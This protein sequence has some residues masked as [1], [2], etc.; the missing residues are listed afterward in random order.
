MSLTRPSTPA[1]APPAWRTWLGRP[2]V[3]TLGLIALFCAAL[4]ALSPEFLTVK[5]LFDVLRACVIPGIFALGVLL[6][7]AAGGIDVSFTAIAVFALY[8]T[9]KLTLGVWP[10]APYP[11]LIGLCLLIGLALGL[12]NGFMVYRFSVPSL[13]VTIGTQY[14]YR[15]FLLA[16]IGTAHIMNIPAAMD[17]FARLNITK[18]QTADGTNV[19]LPVTFLFLVGAALLTQYI[20][21]R[22]LLGRAAYAVG[23]SISIA[24]R[25]G[26]PVRRVTLFVFGYAGLLAGLGGLLHGTQNRLANPFDLVGQELDVIAAVVLGGARVTGGR[27]SVTGTILGVILIVLIKNNLVLMGV[28]STY[29]KLVIGAIILVASGVFARRE[30]R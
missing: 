24:E 17:N 28:P 30:P 20:L 8:G 1:G 12:A 16:F 21:S 14:L 5:T 6:V 2:E 25:L 15:G 3:V 7:L 18:F 11:V 29:Q 10:T 23:G 9:T 27:G 13:I 22:T 26:I 19:S 4:T